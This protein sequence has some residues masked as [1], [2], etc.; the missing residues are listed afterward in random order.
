MLTCP[1]ED[2]GTWTGTWSFRCLEI[3][4]PEAEAAVPPFSDYKLASKGNIHRGQVVFQSKSFDGCDFSTRTC[5][6]GCFPGK[7]S[8][9]LETNR[10]GLS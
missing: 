7:V 8:G 4:W 10:S 3:L 1:A 2:Y 5:P 6:G 9:K